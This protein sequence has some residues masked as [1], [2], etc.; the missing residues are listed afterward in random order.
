MPSQERATPGV[1]EAFAKFV[2]GIREVKLNGLPWGLS[3]RAR[4]KAAHG[5][6][7][8]KAV[9]SDIVAA[10]KDYKTRLVGNTVQIIV[11]ASLSLIGEIPVPD[12][13]LKRSR[14][15]LRSRK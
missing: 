8:V 9:I 15:K 10:G 12:F 13:S 3:E 5:R 14:R 6:D 1:G 2:P 7:E 4:L 11:A